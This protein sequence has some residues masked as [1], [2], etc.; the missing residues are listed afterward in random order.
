MKIGQ[1]NV[2]SYHEPVIVAEMSGNHNRSLERA[3]QLVDLAAQSG[4]Q[5]LKLQTYTADTI[6]LDIDDD[7]FV[8]SEKDSP[9]RGRSFHSLYQE[10]HTPWE[11]QKEI[12][13]KANNLGLLCFSSVFDDS[14]VDFLENLN[15]PAY[16]IASQECIH[17]PLIEK[18][19]STNKPIVM[20][21]GMASLAEIDEAVNLIRKTSSSEILLM[22]CTSTY[23]SNPENSNV[24]TI[25]YLKNIFGCEVGLSDHTLGIGAALAAVSNGA[26]MIE[27]HFTVKRSD[28]G[29]D[30]EFSLEPKEMQS[31]VEESKRAWQSLGKIQFG[32]TKSE[33]VSLSGRRSI[34]ISEDVKAGDILSD[35]NIKIIRPNGGLSPKFY[36]IILGRIIKKDLKKGTPLSWDLF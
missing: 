30:S 36:N 25:P 17:L 21:T 33:K 11:W 13:E 14:S 9:W 10:A 4:V 29:V 5:M 18:V 28:G 8:I 15:I 22:K 34:Y 7:G 23:P 6:T 3:L 20:S 24:L 31:L 16:K 2:D 1:I 27:K 35:E 26:S 12:I 32:P 19:A